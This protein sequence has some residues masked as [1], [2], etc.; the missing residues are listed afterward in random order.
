VRGKKTTQNTTIL[1]LRETPF[2][3]AAEMN[4]HEERIKREEW[5]IIERA[6]RRRL[7]LQKKEY[8]EVIAPFTNGFG[9]RF[10][11][12]DADGN[13]VSNLVR[14]YLTD[15]DEVQIDIDEK[16]NTDDASSTVTCLVKSVTESLMNSYMGTT[17]GMK[18]DLDF[19][20][21]MTMPT[22]EP[23][24]TAPQKKGTKKKS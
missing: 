13:L 7:L 10:I 21:R 12:A 1:R 2:K 9:A 11:S 16:L 20:S 8:R 4:A 5:E 19:S 15:K 14:A 22:P 3:T 17:L 6:R 18:E 24:Q 23:T